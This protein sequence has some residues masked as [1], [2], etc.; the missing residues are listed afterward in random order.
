M[1]MLLSQPPTILDSPD[2]KYKRGAKNFATTYFSISSPK[3]TNSSILKVRAGSSD[4]SKNGFLHDVS[5]F[6]R[7]PCYD[8]HTIDYDFG[9]I[10]VCMYVYKKKL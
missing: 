6:L 4:W 7:H 3:F 10:K 1:P 8:P 2:F 5:T 9:L